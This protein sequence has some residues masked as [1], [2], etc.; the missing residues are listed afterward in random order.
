PGPAGEALRRRLLVWGLG[1]GL[2]LN[3][4]TALGGGAYFFLDRYVAAPVLA[5][6]LIGLVGRLL[7]RASAARAARGDD[8]RSGPVAAAFANL[9]RVAMT[10]YVFQNVLAMLLCYGF[11]LGLAS[12]LAGTGP[13][14][15]IGM[16]AGISLVLLAGSALW[17]RRFDR[18]PL[19]AAQRGFLARIPE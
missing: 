19:E 6:G 12:R 7:D 8:W 1:A 11:G 15:V 14:W 18:G 5:L 3:V 17:L 9:G 16:W 4:A 2:P 10:G 13:W